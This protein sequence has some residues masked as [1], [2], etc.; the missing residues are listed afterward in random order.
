[1]RRMACNIETGI[2]EVNLDLDIS[3]YE[4]RP[5]VIEGRVLVEYFTDPLCTACFV[6][7][8]VMNEL[9]ERFAGIVDF[10]MI[11]GGL[12]PSMSFSTSERLQMATDME[13]LGDRFNMPMSGDVMRDTGVSSSYP[14][15]LAYL[16][17]KKQNSDSANIL[18]RRLREALYVEGLDISKEDV[19]LTLVRELDLDESQFLSDFY[20]VDLLAEL[21]DNIAYT[22]VNGV[23]GFP[24]LVF[25]GL[26]G[27]ST[28]IRGVNDIRAYFDLFEK[29]LVYPEDRKTYTLD[30]VLVSDHFLSE[31]E[32]AEKLNVYDTSEFSEA[33]SDHPNVIVKQVNN[34]SYYRLGGQHE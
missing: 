26:D 27:R 29:S 10:K 30:N 23:S 14:P 16:A 20:S 24:A 34:G 18:M 22:V 33:F 1:M 4:Y 12:V 9:M 31:R 25:Y 19:I 21:E 6:F 28:I 11:M 2:C 17:A 15:S 13:Q 8:P 5:P 32:V 7:E 3:N